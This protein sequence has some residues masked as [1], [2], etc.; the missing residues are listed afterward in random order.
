MSKE[1]GAAK[2]VIELSEGV[3]AVTHGDGGA[4]LAVKSETSPGDW[5]KIIEAL[6]GIGLKW[7]AS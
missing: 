2:I 1:T 3:I 4:L 7:V 5:D 6:K